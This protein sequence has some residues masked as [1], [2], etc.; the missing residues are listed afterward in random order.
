[1]FSEWHR[2]K[3]EYG[4]LGSKIS[5]FFFHEYF[6]KKSEILRVKYTTLNLEI[7]L[8]ATLIA[9][10]DFCYFQLH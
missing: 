1:M 6:Q 8:L 3:T 4:I 10:I 9:S 2:P 7:M 5:V